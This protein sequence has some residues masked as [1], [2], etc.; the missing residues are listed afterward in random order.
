MVIVIILMDDAIILM[1]AIKAEE[2]TKDM[3][4]IIAISEIAIRNVNMKAKT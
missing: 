3:T 4:E 1:N 2:I